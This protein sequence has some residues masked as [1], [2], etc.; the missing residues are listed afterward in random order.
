[1]KNINMILDSKDV[2]KSKCDTYA[3][4]FKYYKDS[5]INSFKIN[6]NDLYLM[7]I[8]LIEEKPSNLITY[9]SDIL[10]KLKENKV[11]TDYKVKKD[12]FEIYLS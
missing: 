12:I 11:I 9:L 6:S 3:K 8:G 5:K 10:D 7:S 4:H 1:M 2:Y